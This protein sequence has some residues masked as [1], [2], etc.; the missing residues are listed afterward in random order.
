MVYQVTPRSGIMGE[1]LASKGDPLL[2]KIAMKPDV[3]C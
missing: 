3:S 1:H 2:P